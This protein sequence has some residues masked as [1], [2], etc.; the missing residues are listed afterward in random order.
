[1]KVNCSAFL[2]EIKQVFIAEIILDFMKAILIA[3]H[4][5]FNIA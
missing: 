3:T 5:I 4:Y 2:G 1:M